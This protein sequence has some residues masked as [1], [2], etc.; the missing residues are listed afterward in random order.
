MSCIYCYRRKCNII[1]LNDKWTLNERWAQS[2]RFVIARWALCERTHCERT[3]K[4]RENGKVEGFG[5]CIYPMMDLNKKYSQ[6]R[7][8]QNTLSNY[9][10]S[11]NSV[12]TR[13]IISLI[14]RLDDHA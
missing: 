13:I 3:V 4:A 5:D 11:L 8:K 2:E 6:E 7:K 1:W 9:W 10:K 12:K 14:F